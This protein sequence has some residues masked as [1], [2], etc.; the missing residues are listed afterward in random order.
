MYTL[1]AKLENTFSKKHTIFSECTSSWPY[2]QRR[3]N[4]YFQ[5]LLKAVLWLYTLVE[6]ILRTAGTAKPPW[7]VFSRFAVGSG[8][9]TVITELQCGLYGL[10]KEKDQERGRG[11]ERGK[12][13]F[14]EKCQLLEAEGIKELKSLLYKQHD[15]WFQQGS[16]M[17][18]KI[19][20]WKVAGEEDSHTVSK[21]LPHTLLMT[22]ANR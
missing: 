5:Y 21:L 2:D 12:L 17:E 20:G 18:A 16:S 15:N 4:N 11:R 3:K 1:G 19:T 7:T 9:G 22:E 14:T 13:F 10:E 6:Y 8:T